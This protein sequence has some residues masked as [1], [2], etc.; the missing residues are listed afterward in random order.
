D[1]G[2]P[3]RPRRPSKAKL[4]SSNPQRG[5]QAGQV[6]DQPQDPRAGRCQRGDRQEKKVQMGGI[7]V[8]AGAIHRGVREEGPG[9]LVEGAEVLLEPLHVVRELRVEREEDDRN[10]QEQRKRGGVGLTERDGARVLSANSQRL[11]LRARSSPLALKPSG[12]F[13]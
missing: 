11:T 12:S 8:V 9:R 10:G 4:A 5:D 1:G 3:S 6:R 7:E 2:H 13:P